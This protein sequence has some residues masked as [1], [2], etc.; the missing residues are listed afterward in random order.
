MKKAL[1]LHAWFSN[2]TSNWYPWL[3]GELEKKGYE[4]WVPELP[5]MPTENPDME[6][7]LKFVIEKNFVDES[8]TVIGHSLGSVLTLRLAERVKF[9]KG[10]L[11]AAWDYN[12][13]TPEHQSFW[14][15]MMDH[16]KILSNVSE[17]VFPL[18]ENDPYVTIAIA[19]EV[20]ARLNGKVIEVG[21][22][23][24]FGKDDGVKEV[25]EILEFV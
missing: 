11:F 13:L 25:P 20:A 18:S 23:G 15:N 21:K 17:W 5:T 4:I 12:D 2:P 19:K 8:T 10:I 3:K 1:I 14:R 7:M 9:A 24:H 6:T 16:K 22:K